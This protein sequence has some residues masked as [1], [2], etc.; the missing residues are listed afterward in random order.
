MRGL[1]FGRRAKARSRERLGD[2]LV[3]QGLLELADLERALARQRELGGHL[4]T[5]IIDLG[6]VPED[7]VL[8]LLGS[9]LEA[10]TVARRELMISS[11]AVRE[12]LPRDVAEK[13]RVVPF[14]V[15]GHTL[16]LASMRPLEQEVEKSIGK[17]TDMLPLPHVALEIR[18]SEALRRFYGL[19]L[20]SRLERLLDR[21]AMD[22]PNLRDTQP[23]S[24]GVVIDRLVPREP[25]TK[26]PSD[27]SLWGGLEIE[28]HPPNKQQDPLAWLRAELEGGLGTQRLAE[29]AGSPEL[30]LPGL[31]PL[32]E[33]LALLPR[34]HKREQIA[35]V[36]LYG[37]SACCRRRLLLAIRGDRVVGWRG[38]GDGVVPLRVLT[39]NFALDESPVLHTLRN[40]MPR[41]LG[42]LPRH[43]SHDK[44]ARALGAPARDCIL[45]PLA[46]RDKVV[47]FCY[48]DNLGQTIA[49]APIPQLEEL[50][51]QGSVALGTYLRW[52]KLRINEPSSPAL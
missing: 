2:L 3:Q 50:M 34:L 41:W 10:P 21:L 49:A 6:L 25:G 14:N 1:R 52:R 22:D 4:G 23:I 5:N 51:L 44:L 32:N 7:V 37:L 17:V 42:A 27:E 33:A 12:K 28:D 31:D 38:E 39:L 35:A 46:I 20:P 19:P 18:L 43:P 26:P 13:Y 29:Q 24:V 9:Q 36:L 45:L 48:A 47:A 8:T 16:M 11:P 30:P 40:G 15:K